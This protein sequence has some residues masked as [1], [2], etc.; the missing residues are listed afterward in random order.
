MCRTVHTLYTGCG[1]R[2]F[3]SY[4]RRCAQHTLAYT[5]GRVRYSD[6]CPHFEPD[7]TIWFGDANALCGQCRVERERERL[8]SGESRG[9]NRSRR[10]APYY[11]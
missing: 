8:A 4:R 9:G 7:E 1:H 3:G 6:P 2:R 5:A 11:T 10:W